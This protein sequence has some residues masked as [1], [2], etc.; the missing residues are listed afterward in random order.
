MYINF[1]PYPLKKFV[2][3]YISVGNFFPFL[4]QK[5]GTNLLIKKKITALLS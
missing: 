4:L 3:I 2:I 5:L 1:P